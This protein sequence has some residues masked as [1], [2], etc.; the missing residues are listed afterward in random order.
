MGTQIENRYRI[1]QLLGK[2]SSGVT[3][4]A[5]DTATGQCVAVK[6]LSLKGL[7]DWKKLE[8][9]EREAKILAQLQHPAIPKYIDYF[10]IDTEDNRRFYL[11]Q[12]LAKGQSL[13]DWVT[14]GRRFSEAEVRDIALKVLRV[15]QYLHGLSPA[16]IHRDIK[17]QNIVY[18]E[19][20]S[21]C[22]VDFGAVQT[23]VRSAIAPGSTVVGT[24]GYMAPEQFSGQAS[25]AT[26]L[27]GLGA[28]L[29]YLLTHRD[30]ADLPCR[31]LKVEFRAHTS[32]SDGL[33]NWLEGL[34]EPM[35]EDRFA[36]A[37]AAI[38]ALTSRSTQEPP[39]LPLSSSK[40]RGMAPGRA[41]LPQLQ[42]LN[43]RVQLIR[44][45]HYLLLKI[46]ASGL[47]WQGIEIAVCAGLCFAIP[48]YFAL[49][50][51]LWM[52]FWLVG[53]GLLVLLVRLCWEKV[54]LEVKGGHFMIERRIFGWK[55]KC[56]GRTEA[57]RTV[58]LS[59]SAIRI[60]DEPLTAIALRTHK[61]VY[62]LGTLLSRE[63]KRWLV[64]ELQDFLA[65][66]VS[67]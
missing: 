14:A 9:F 4:Q 26:D 51:P 25:P 5:E 65:N 64:Q 39:P 58:G 19:A 13:A 12:E 6:E 10:Q 44:R 22:L 55:R 38:S 47:Q 61:R 34:L 66:P 21:V 27:Y 50:E 37:E 29:L 24:Y 31:R 56:Q 16:V 8:L 52:L 30:P 3:Y 35:E 46:P 11:V 1:L 36:G 41:V 42:S 2:G 18:T 15:L 40:H 28:T 60:S 7:G 23:V 67:S 48:T 49:L 57:I 62:T 45:S 43:S 20:G 59:T 63:E 17:P 54:S 33:A 32:I 53:A